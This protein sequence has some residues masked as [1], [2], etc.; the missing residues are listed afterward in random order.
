MRRITLSLLT[1]LSAAA[2]A[3]AD[4]GKCHRDLYIEAVRICKG[5]SACVGRVYN[6]LSVG[7]T[8][9]GMDCFSGFFKNG[10]YK[11]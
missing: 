8:R 5:N 1:I 6:Q 7:D 11:K 3:F 2:P 10:P 9:G 4:H